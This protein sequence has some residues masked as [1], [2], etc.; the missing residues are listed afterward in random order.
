[1]CLFVHVCACRI[2]TKPDVVMVTP[3]YESSSQ[4]CS[5]QA[6]VTS[7]SGDPQREKAVILAEEQ[8]VCVCACVRACVCMCVRV[9]VRACVCAC[10]CVWFVLPVFL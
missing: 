2:S 5:R 1:M 10:V 6:L 9:C 7:V 3:Q 4:V 8:G